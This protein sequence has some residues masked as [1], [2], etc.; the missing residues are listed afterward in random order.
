MDQATTSEPVETVDP[1]S[2]AAEAAEDAEFDAAFNGTPTE[3]RALPAPATEPAPTPEPPA[4]EY[5]Q[6][7]KAERD[8]LL[9]GVTRVDTIQASLDKM[10]GQSSSRFGRLEDRLK[11]FDSAPPGQPVEL[12]D[13][14][15]A[16]MK[17]E[18]PEFAS[19]Q[20]KT[21]ER[22]LS[23]L[24]GSGAPAFDEEKIHTLV[25]S[26]VTPEIQRV[27][28]EAAVDVMDALE[29]DWRQTVNSPELRAWI[30]TKPPDYQKSFE[31]TWKPSEM[32]KIIAEFREQTKPAPPAAPVPTPPRA[33]D[34]RFK[35]ALVPK[36]TGGPASPASD[37]DEFEQGYKEASGH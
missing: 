7:T 6:L 20:R 37:E 1:A 24:K 23:R 17:A 15:F 4:P 26:R 21:M 35:A 12:N 11:H 14:D 33:P 25:Q 9:S 34:G 32:R 3:P 16:E 2:A 10:W 13:E 30:A 8:Q 28:E 19:M 18:F 22:I 29:P 5:V 27:R 31:E 36:G